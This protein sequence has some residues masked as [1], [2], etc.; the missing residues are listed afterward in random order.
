M[1]EH[2]TKPKA[3]VKLDIETNVQTGEGRIYLKQ[4]NRV[5]HVL[6]LRA[7]EVEFKGELVLKTGYVGDCKSVMLYKCPNGYFLFCDKAFGKN[8]WSAIGQ[9]FEE[10][11]AKVSNEEIKKKL[12][13]GY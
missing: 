5:S 10:V 4:L 11:I 6:F 8:N 12:N 3:V 7:A 2:A 9:T 13:D 1:T